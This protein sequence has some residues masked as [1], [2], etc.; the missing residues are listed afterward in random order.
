MQFP[1]SCQPKGS[2]TRQWSSCLRVSQ[3]PVKVLQPMLFKEAQQSHWLT[4][5]DL[6][7]IIS[8]LLVFCVGKQTF[9]H[10]LHPKKGHVALHLSRH[11]V[12]G[13]AFK[14]T[15]CS[16]RRLAT[17]IPSMNNSREE[18]CP[19]A[20][21][22]KGSSPW[23]LGLLALG[24]TSCPW[25]MYMVEDNFLHHDVEDAECGEAW[26]SG[27]PFQSTPLMTYFL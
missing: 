3:A 23:S 9:V 14:S 8:L 11:S 20:Q 19:W 17:H 7:G 6:G 24:R 2:E 27:I 10:I 1:C 22:F 12:G 18:R 4:K 26:G 13:Q 25:G 5:L 16:L 21:S 15:V